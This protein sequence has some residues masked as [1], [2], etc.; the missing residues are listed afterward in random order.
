MNNNKE[1]V[2]DI[3]Q[4]TLDVAKETITHVERTPGGETNESYFATVAGKKYVVRLPGK[5]TEV[6]I[7]RSIEKENL[8]FGTKLGINPAFVYFD[9]TSGIKIS[10]AI[11]AATPLTQATAR[12]AHIFHKLIHLFQTLH[13]TDDVMSNR[14]D[15]FQKINEYEQLAFAAN[16]VTLQQIVP[17]RSEIHALQQVYES[18]D[19]VDV[20]APCHMDSVIINILQDKTDN[21][22]LIDWEYSGMFDPLWD[23]ATLIL[24]LELNEEEEHYFLTNYFRREPTVDEL[25]RLHLLKIFL[26]YYWSLW[27][28]YKETQG[29]NFG[30]KGTARIQRA[31]HHLATYKMAYE[32]DVV[33]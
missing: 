6:L 20:E 28:I 23:I 9:E 22:Y 11:E 13:E 7:D 1:M 12:D 16:S 17:L 15:L 27:Y 33:V 29:D 30:N 2:Y 10:H 18:Y 21:L 31:K 26:D 8:T 3:I 32:V 14:F 24:S 25:Q 5:G 4:A 19:I